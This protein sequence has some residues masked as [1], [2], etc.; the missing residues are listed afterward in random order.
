MAQLMDKTKSFSSRIGPEN[1]MVSD[2]DFYIN[3]PGVFT[4][5]YKKG[6][7]PLERESA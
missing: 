4:L 3:I 7:I 1:L 6:R 5:F 2:F